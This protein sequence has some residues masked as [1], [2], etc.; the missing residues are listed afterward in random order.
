MRYSGMHAR[1]SV[2]TE[3]YVIAYSVYVYMYLYSMYGVCSVCMQP[4]GRM[5]G[6]ASPCT[7][8]PPP[9]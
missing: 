6:L 5:A 8:L 4:C 3:V 1:Y 9:Y 7:L 2:C